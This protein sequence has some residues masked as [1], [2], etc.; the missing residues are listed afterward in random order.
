MRTSAGAYEGT[1]LEQEKQNNT[2]GSVMLFSY[3]GPILAAALTGVG[4][5][6]LFRILVTADA[7]GLQ[8]SRSD[9]DNLTTDPTLPAQ[10]KRN[11][12]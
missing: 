9:W 12:A 7:G 11:Q 6:Y 3:I 5:Y 2:R 8:I 4:V 1:F 10:E